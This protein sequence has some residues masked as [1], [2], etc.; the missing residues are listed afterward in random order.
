MNHHWP[1][2][3]RLVI[4]SCVLIAGL[5]ILE[6]KKKK[7]KKQMLSCLFSGWVVCNHTSLNLL[8]ETAQVMESHGKWSHSKKS[9]NSLP[10][11]VKY[12]AYLWLLAFQHLT[13]LGSCRSLFWI[14]LP[15]CRL[16]D[17]FS[18]SSFKA[19]CKCHLPSFYPG[20]NHRGTDHRSY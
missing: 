14:S 4:G 11:G 10:A 9:L 6:K 12:K 7:K 3:S 18:L 1:G 8:M 2:S 20:K 16:I 13:V 17:T 15:S 19:H 5:N